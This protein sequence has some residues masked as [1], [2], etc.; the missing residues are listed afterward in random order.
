M[1]DA[2]WVGN[3]PEPK[4]SNLTDFEDREINKEAYCLDLD[5]FIIPLSRKEDFL[6]WFIDNYRS[7]AKDYLWEIFDEVGSYIQA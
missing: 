1:K 5:G 4:L 7:E 6:E 2:P 3:P